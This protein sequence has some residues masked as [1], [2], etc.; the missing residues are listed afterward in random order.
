MDSTSDEAV[1]HS[2]L[3]TTADP[4]NVQENEIRQFRSSGFRLASGAA[5]DAG[6][7]E[8]Q[9]LPRSG[10]RWM[11]EGQ[12]APQ[13]LVLVQPLCTVYGMVCI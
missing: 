1:A 7:R 5:A 4:K 3:L 11:I 10:A 2:Y 8:E 6:K 9:D 12:G 13:L